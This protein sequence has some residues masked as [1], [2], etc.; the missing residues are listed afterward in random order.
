MENLAAAGSMERGIE[1]DEEK[2]SPREIRRCDGSRT[3]SPSALTLVP[4]KCEALQA[5]PLNMGS[6]AA[7]AVE[8]GRS[9][10]NLKKLVGFTSYF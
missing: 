2:W 6:V 3:C 10:P 9:D 8:Y 5:R 1:V 7:G 4:L